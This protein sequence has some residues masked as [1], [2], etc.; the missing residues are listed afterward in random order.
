VKQRGFSLI[1]FALVAGVLAV[2]GSIALVSLV[3]GPNQAR[4][5]EVKAAIH[6]I[7]IA[8]ERYAVDSGG[9]YPVFLVGAERDSNILQ[10]YRNLSGNGVTQFPPITPFAAGRN[11][12]WPGQ[13]G[14]GVVMDALLEGYYLSEYP[15]N[16]FA[17]PDSGM[18]HSMAVDGWRLGM[19]PYGGLH[20]DKMFDLGFGWGDTPQ[21]DFVLTNVENIDENQARNSGG[22][23]DPDNDA[24]GNFYY[25]PVF[26][27]ELPVFVHST[28]ASDR[29]HD[30]DW[31]NRNSPLLSEK[32]VGYYLYG[33]GGPG[34]RES[35]EEGGQDYFN[36]MPFPREMSPAVKN[37]YEMFDCATP[38][39]TVDAENQKRVET[40]GYPAS[41]FDP[42]TGA[43]P[44]GRDPFRSEVQGMRSGPDG[45]NDWVIIEVTSFINVIQ[46][47][48]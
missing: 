23:S 17:R 43:W 32:V 29:M 47:Q 28:Y 21:T 37:Q 26:Y 18:W 46:D 10:C 15:V 48:G 24:P 42:W 14:G 16:P 6:K 5:E 34:A 40:T 30:N 3:K 38:D 4:E 2:T 39:T 7:Q 13:P 45:V 22:A 19:Y 35:F 31:R 44:Y 9:F 11:G 27:D 33:Y 41:E 25:H 12:G 36:R 1:E 20:G 8:L